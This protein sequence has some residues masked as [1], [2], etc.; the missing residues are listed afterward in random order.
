M[1][2]TSEWIKKDERRERPAEDTWSVGE[3][4][5]KRALPVLLKTLLPRFWPLLLSGGKA[6][7]RLVWSEVRRWECISRMLSVQINEGSFRGVSQRK[8]SPPPFPI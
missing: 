2:T 7:Q 6:G 1:Y 4:L 3:E 5:L 8:S